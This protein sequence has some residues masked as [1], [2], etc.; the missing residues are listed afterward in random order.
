VSSD[1]KKKNVLKN[2]VLSQML[3]LN[4]YESNVRRDSK[5]GTVTLVVVLREIQ[6]RK[7]QN[8]EKDLA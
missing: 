4:N 8:E 6:N 7:E 3:E 2:L 5:E 1:E